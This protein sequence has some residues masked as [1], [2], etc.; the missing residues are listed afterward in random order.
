VFVR[1]GSY[2]SVRWVMVGPWV[3]VCKRL[4]PYLVGI[5]LQEKIRSY[6]KVV[7]RLVVDDMSGAAFQYRMSFVRKIGKKRNFGCSIKFTGNCST[8]VCGTLL[9]G[10][11]REQ[12]G[13]W[14]GFKASTARRRMRAAL[15]C[16][17]V[18]IILLWCGRLGT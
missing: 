15:A 14:Y 1:Y 18:W 5:L 7:M 8:W 16:C 2:S 9:H 17:G 6:G 13:G 11:G 4:M 3:V 10:R 12:R